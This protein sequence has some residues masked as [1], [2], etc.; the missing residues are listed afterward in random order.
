MVNKPSH[1][2]VPLNMYVKS[3]KNEALRSCFSYLLYKQGREGLINNYYLQ[4]S[5]WHLN[6]TGVKSSK[7]NFRIVKTGIVWS[8]NGYQPINRTNF[9]NNKTDKTGMHVFEIRGFL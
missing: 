6:N 3:L 2:T 5:I 4:Y 9:V 8:I 7:Q 1:A